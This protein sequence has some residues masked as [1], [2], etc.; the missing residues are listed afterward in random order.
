MVAYCVAG[1][2]SILTMSS[3]RTVWWDT[4]DQIYTSLNQR[5]HLRLDSHRA[6]FSLSETVRVI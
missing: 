3:E 4:S 1:K 5:S 6:R 2:L